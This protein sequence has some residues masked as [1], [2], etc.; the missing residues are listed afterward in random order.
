[1]NLPISFIALYDEA[2]AYALSN[3]N[4]V[5]DFS[6]ENPNY[7]DVKSPQTPSEFD[8]HSYLL[9]KTIAKIIIG[10]QERLQLTLDVGT[11]IYSRIRKITNTSPQNNIQDIKNT[12]DSIIAYFV[13]VGYMKYAYIDWS[14]LD[15]DR[16]EREG[17]G[18]FIYHMSEPIIFESAKRLYREDGFAQHISSRVFQAGLRDIDVIGCEDENFNP[19][20]HKENDVQELWMIHKLNH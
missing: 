1:M 16:W 17:K 8:K 20:T 11:Y 13:S 7:V 2:I 4:I 19:N 12:L 10:H 6:K 14:C 18:T 3:Q 15:I 9:F 5:L